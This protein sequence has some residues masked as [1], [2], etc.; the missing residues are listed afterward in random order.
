MDNIHKVNPVFFIFSGHTCV[1]LVGNV[2]EGLDKKERQKESM[3]ASA[4]GKQKARTI[5]NLPPQRNQSKHDFLVLLGQG[6]LLFQIQQRLWQCSWLLER[7]SFLELSGLFCVVIMQG[8]IDISKARSRQ[9]ARMYGARGN[10]LTIKMY[11]KLYWKTYERRTQ[12]Y[13]LYV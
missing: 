6:S 8:N 3:S 1:S 2:V 4:R 9:I 12:I 11:V 10:L 5:K 7:L 13:R